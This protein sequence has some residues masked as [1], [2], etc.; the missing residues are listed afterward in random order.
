M[1]ELESRA[2]WLTA[3]TGAFLAVRR[4]DYRAV[5][6]TASMDHLLPLYVREQGRLVVYVAD[7]VATDRPI[8]GLRQQFR[9]RSRTATRGIRANLSMA[10]RWPQRHRRAHSP[11]VAKLPLGDR[12][13]GFVAGPATGWPPAAQPSRV[14]PAVTSALRRRL[15]AVRP[16][17]AAARAGTPRV[18]RGERGFRHL[19]RTSSAGADETGA[20]WSG[21]GR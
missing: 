7:A 4:S 2:G 1:R 18:H 3:V 19:L 11:S 20:E 21:P 13:L 10:R 16:A 5:P 12:C 17:D 6:A 9:S 14:V 8:S 15:P